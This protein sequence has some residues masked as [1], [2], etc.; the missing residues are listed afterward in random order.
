MSSADPAREGEDRPDDDFDAIVAAWRD[1]GSV[2]D[3]PAEPVERADR[4]DRGDAGD[5]AGAAGGADRPAHRPGPAAPHPGTGTGADPDDH[6]HPPEPPPLPRPGPPAV[7]GGGLIA[8]SAPGAGPQALAGQRRRAHDGGG[9]AELRGPDPGQRPVARP[10]EDAGVVLAGGVEEQRRRRRHPARD[11]HEVRVEHVRDEREPLPQPAAHVVDGGAGDRVP[12]AGGRGDP[13]AGDPPR[14]DGGLAG[15]PGRARHV[16]AR[17]HLQRGGGQG[18]PAAVALPA[19]ALAAR[20]G[21]PVRDHPQVPQLRCD[22]VRTAEQLAVEQQGAADPGAQRDHQGHRGTRRGAVAPLGERGGVRVVLHDDRDPAEPVADPLGDRGVAPGQVR[23]VADEA[24]RGVDETGQRQPDGGDGVPAPQLVDGA[25][26]GRLQRVVG[27]RGR[28]G[29]GVEDLP[30]GVDDARAHA[31]APDV[32]PDGADVGHPGA[33]VRCTAIRCTERPPP[34]GRRG[35]WRAGGAASSSTATSTASSPPAWVASRVTSSDRSPRT[36]AISAHTGQA[37]QEPASPGPGSLP[38]ARSDGSRPACHGRSRGHPGAR[39]GHEGDHQAGVGAAAL[40]P[41]TGGLA[42]AQDR[43][44]RDHAPGEPDADDHVVADPGEVQRGVL[45]AGQR[46]V[47]LELGVG[48]D[49]VTCGAAQLHQR[50]RRGAA[51]GARGV[52]VAVDRQGQLAQRTDAGRLGGGVA[53]RGHRHVRTELAQLG[54]H[55]LLLGGAFAQPARRGPA[56]RR[57]R[58]GHHPVRHQRVHPQLVQGQRGQRAAGLGGHHPLRGQHQPDR[59][60]GTVGEQAAQP[61]QLLG[62][63]TERVDGAVPARA[64]GLGPGEPGDQAAHRAAVRGEQPLQVARQRLGQGEQPQRL[65]GRAAVD[66]DDVVLAGVGQALHLDQREEVLDAGQHG[67]L[68]GDELVHPGPGEHR[69]QV[70]LQVAPGALEQ[71]PG[72]DVGAP[73]VLGDLGGLGAQLGV[74]RVAEGVRRVGGHDQRGPAG[75]GHLRGGRGGQG[76][77]ADPALAGEQH[78]AHGG[79]LTIASGSPPTGSALLDAALETLQ[80][81]VDDH[82]L[83]LATEHPDHREVDLDAELVGDGGAAGVAD[84]PVRAVLGALDAALHQRP[85]HRAVVGGPVVVEGVGVLDDAGVHREADLAGAAVGTG[86]EDL[87]A[88]DL[89]G[90]LGVGLEVRDHRH[91]R[92]RRGVDVDRGRV[93]G[94]DALGAADPRAAVQRLVHVPEQ[95]VRRLLG[96]DPRG[97]RR[98][99]DLGATGDD[100]VGQA[101]VRRRD[102]G[103]QHVGRAERVQARG[104]VLV[105]H[106]VRPPGA[107][108]ARVDPGRE[109]YP[110]EETEPATADLDHPSVGAGDAVG[111]GPGVGDVDVARDRP[112]RYPE[113]AQDAEDLGVLRGHGLG[114]RGG[115]VGEPGPGALQQTQHLRA[116]RPDPAHPAE[117]RGHLGPE[118]PGDDPVGRVAVVDELQQV[119][120]HQHPVGALAGAGERDGG[121]VDVGDDVQPH[122]QAVRSGRN[123]DGATPAGRPPSRRR[124][125]AKACALNARCRRSDSARSHRRRRSRPPGGGPSGSARRKKCRTVPSPSGSHQTSMVP[126]S[127]PVTVQRSPAGPRSCATSGRRSG[128]YDGHRAGSANSAA[129]RSRGTARKVSSITSIAGT[130][131]A[132]HPVRRRRSRVPSRPGPDRQHHRSIRYVRFDVRG[133]YSPVGSAPRC[134]RSRRGD[135]VQ[136]VEAAR[137]SIPVR[138]YSVPAAVSVGD[139]ESLSDAVFDNAAQHPS[140]VLYRR[141][142]ADGSWSEV[143]AAE[144]GEQVTRIA[145]G[146]VAA[147]VQAGDRVALLSRTRFEWTLFDYAILAAGAVTV[148]IYET[149]SPD[150][151]SW[152][153]SDSGAVGI[154]VET[155]EHAASVEKVRG[156]LPELRTVWQIEPAASAPDAP[157]AVEQLRGLGADTPDDVVHER[158]GGVRADDLCT[159]IYTSGTTGRPKGCELTHRNLIA[160][161][162]TIAA[163]IPHL[164]EPGDSVL[165]FLPLAHVFGKAIQCGCAVHPHHRR[166]LPRRQE[167]AARP[168]GL[169]ADVPARGAPGVREGLQRRAPQGPQRGQGQDLRRGRGHRDRLQPLD[170]GGANLLLKARHALFDKLVY[171]KLRAAVGGQV[172]AAVSG[173]APLGDR[174]GHFFRGI[175]LPVL[176]GYGLTE[177]SAG[178]TINTL[179]AQRVGS[180]GRPVPGCAVRIAS[181]GEIMLSGDIVF[182]GYWKN[183]EATKAAVESDGWFHSGDIGELDDAGFLTITGRKKEIIVTAGGKNVAPAVLEDRLRAHP[184]VGQCIVIGDQKP[185]IAALVTIDP[186]ALP[187]WRERNGK[188]VGEAS[189]A[190]DLVDDPELRGEIAAAVEEA[191]QAVSR[192]EQIRKFTILPRDFSEAGGEITPTMKVKRKVVV[193]SYSGEIEALYAGTTADRG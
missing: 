58:A 82:L 187:G 23:G 107:G 63:H 164:F 74:Q 162:R 38:A 168:G 50:P 49:A 6:Y 108:A 10:G 54:E 48:G 185:F 150:Q 18:G 11:H 141:K 89:V 30:L 85:A 77:L 102:V 138:E 40:Q 177:T 19:A 115:R 75:P 154:V 14:I 146:L 45:G 133:P 161:I 189:S 134:R 127:A 188:P 113:P 180:V 83:G 24:A 93:S 183:E 158:R 64:V 47:E 114:D 55:G 69:A 153:V 167:P 28:R 149:S 35:S 37:V 71:V 175:G 171:G 36:T 52:V 42:A 131:S 39:V 41:G 143:T 56:Q 124:L 100:V 80:R 105:G 157:S 17:E 78:D 169:P 31:G 27:T 110:A 20:A 112:D 15:Q 53:D 87:D 135:R 106:E 132:C 145:A 101:R 178:I 34:C 103:A 92:L 86:V 159:L 119:A 191:N 122:A 192:A 73:Q 81:G 29:G 111:V 176:E 125:S 144:F 104:P 4:T 3:W 66:D 156:D 8:R 79:S 96:P 2:P 46:H 88:G 67:Q 118:Q 21:P 9:R 90:P 120:E 60:A 151:I 98:A 5:V 123:A 65:R 174:L 62:Q 32:H 94:V 116:R 184:L 121:A 147:G 152:I 128:Q 186:E 25:G 163:T 182:R 68:V 99:G 170:S 13:L 148:P 70:P 97:Q 126:T 26:D 166:P 1:E 51:G 130:R 43:R 190:A 129:T 136:P 165:L 140:D 84:Q 95:G 59:G 7:V 137:R 61:A 172:V 142:G 57:R 76:R 179:D 33:H 160:E 117:L 173:S 12:L 44:Q 193:E 181:D 155:A 139:E 72:L 109:R 91:D 16:A 22:T